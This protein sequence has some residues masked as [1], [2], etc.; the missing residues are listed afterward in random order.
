MRIGIF[1]GTFDP[2]HVGH[3]IAAQEV[4]EQLGLDRLLLIPAAV[5]PHKRDETVSPGEVRLEMLRAAVAGDDRFEVSEVELERDGPSYTVDTLRALRTDHPDAELFLAMGA[6]QLDA[7]DTWK[8]PDEIVG[9]AT[10][11]TFGRSGTEPES[12]GRPVTRVEVPEID[13]SSTLIRQRVAR[14]APIRYLVAAGVESIIRAS[15]LYRG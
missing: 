4:Y 13:I 9:L 12:G 11:V 1:G 14:G 3:L 15:A 2:P 10:L 5:P 7:F 6:D 8:A